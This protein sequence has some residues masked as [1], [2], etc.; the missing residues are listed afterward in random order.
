[1]KRIYILFLLLSISIK[2][3]IPAGYY[4][5]AQG[6]TGYQLKTALKNIITNGHNPQSY[7]DLYNCYETSDIDN[8]YENDGTILDMY[9]ENPNGP[10]PYNYTPNANHC[11][12]YSNEGD[13]FNR[14]HTIPQNFFNSSSTPKAD[15]HFVVPTDGKVN[16][17]RSNYPY[18]IV[19]NPTW[20][21]QNG[22]KLG[23]N[24][25]SGYSSKVFE[26]IDEFKGDIARMAF[27]FAT[28]Y[29]D[30]IP[31]WYNGSTSNTADM[32]NGTSNQVFSNWFLQILLQWHYNDPVSTR[33]IDRN[34]AVYD[35]QDNRNPYIDHPEWVAQI[36]D[37]SNS[38][39]T[40]NKNLFVVYP[41]PSKNHQITISLINNVENSKLNIFNLL[42]QK[43]NLNTKKKSNKITISQIPT[44]IYL[45]QIEFDSKIVT[46]KIIIE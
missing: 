30:N 15:A 8:Y 16:G 31:G 45:L 5:N 27:Y 21:S 12:N 38:V 22:S 43:I 9:S 4:D 40:Q 36:W 32:F 26:P 3:Q 7:G 37:P 33:E 46:N 39:Q 11:G 19:N 42:G 13:C 20:T 14:E 1:M 35:F 18:G 44:G 6:L 2:A 25:T 24:S 29:E 10:D 17:Q 28:R 41:N 23:N 34:N